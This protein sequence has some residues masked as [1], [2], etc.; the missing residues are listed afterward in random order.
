MEITVDTTVEKLLELYPRAAAFLQE[1]GIVCFV[2]GEPAWGTL[3]ELIEG[4]GLNPEVTFV[5][6]LDFLGFGN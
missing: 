1:Q 2:C 6:L 5:K 3:R 4:K